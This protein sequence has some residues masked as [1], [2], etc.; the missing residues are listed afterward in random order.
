VEFKDT[1]IFFEIIYL[2]FSGLKE[3]N[4]LNWNDE[5]GPPML[6]IDDECKLIPAN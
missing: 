5:A 1:K 3:A 6:D 2:K 4:V